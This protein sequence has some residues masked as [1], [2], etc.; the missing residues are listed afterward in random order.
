MP[1]LTSVQEKA[2]S[3]IFDQSKAKGSA[4]TLRELCDYMGYKAIGS[5]QDLVKAL[6]RKGFLV[7]P[8]KQRARSLRLTDR[9]F[10]MFEGLAESVANTFSGENAVDVP[11]LGAVP[12]G[13][14]VEAIEER[15]GMIRMSLS[16]F[17]KPVRHT[18][19]LFAVR[20]SGLSMVEAGILDGDWL[21]A[22]SCSD[23]S[24]GDVVIAR[25]TDDATVKTLRQDERGW[26]LQPENPDFAPIY[27][28]ESP[29]EVVGRV[30][31]LQRF[32]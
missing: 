15:V 20:A 2:L 4:P 27:A 11:C 24:N 13:N 22:E 23:A 16:M 7:Q 3:F 21:V 9:A 28:D 19:E 5:A 17:A 31:A 6:R 25:L 18:K 14:P 32:L 12:A 26:F 8:E 30:V 1:E 29:F 10:F